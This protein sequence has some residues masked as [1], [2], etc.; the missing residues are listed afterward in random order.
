MK[1]NWVFNEIIYIIRLKM[2]TTITISYKTRMTAE[3]RLNTKVYNV[4][5]VK[6]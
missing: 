6:L 1:I 5:N 3:I 4:R 2:I